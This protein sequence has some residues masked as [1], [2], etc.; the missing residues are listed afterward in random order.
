MIKNAFAFLCA[1]ASKLVL[2][3]DERHTELN[4]EK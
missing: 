3:N 2:I 1:F 4:Q